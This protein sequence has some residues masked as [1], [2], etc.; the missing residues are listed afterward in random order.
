MR[1]S[2]PSE[3]YGI[4]TMDHCGHGGDGYLRGSYVGGGFHR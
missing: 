3:K 1:G 4:V 2:H